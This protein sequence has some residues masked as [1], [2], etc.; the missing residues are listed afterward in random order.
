MKRLTILASFLFVLAGPA[1]AKECR[2]PD[3]KPGQAIQVPDACKDVLR[4]KNQRVDALRGDRSAIDLG[5]GTTLRIGGR[6]RAETGWK[7]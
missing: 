4:P 3:P 7:R 2:I 1:L 6:V 5:S